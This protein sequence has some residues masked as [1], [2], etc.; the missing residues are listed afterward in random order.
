MAGREPDW[1]G[2]GHVWREEGGEH[3]VGGIVVGGD[4]EACV[5]EGV[6]FA[7]EGG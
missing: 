5:F 6:G 1:A 2:V 7:E 4:V 3:G